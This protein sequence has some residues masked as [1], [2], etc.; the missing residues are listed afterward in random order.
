MEETESFRRNTFM[1]GRTLPLVLTIFAFLLPIFFVPN[2]A[3][4]FELSK[5]YLA[6][7]AVALIFIVFSIQT[8]RSGVLKFR[9]SAL[10]FAV[11]VLPL[12]YLLSALFSSVPSL[13]FFGYE[14]DQ[15]TFGFMALCAA[16]ALSVTLAADSE[17]RVAAVLRA[18]YVGGALMLLFQVI[19]LLFHAPINFGLF[20]SPIQ[21]LLGKWNDLALFAG[22]MGSLS[23]LIFETVQLS[24]VRNIFVWVTL[25]LS[26]VVLVLANLPL[27]WVLFGLASFILLIFSFMRR[28]LHRSLAGAGGIA[29][30]VALALVV[31]FLFFGAR[32]STTLQNHFSISALEVSPSM[33]GTLGVLENVYAKR[34]LVGS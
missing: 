6:L 9:S 10:L 21:N 29:S 28:H 7:I 14:I 20:S 27:A 19:Q 15:D 33:K 11:L 8:L 13:S 4:P 18:L 31:F 34:P 23:L 17:S 24:T 2:A 16:L 22:F 30:L 12:T 26:V 3:F 1:T 25:I 5:A 32:V